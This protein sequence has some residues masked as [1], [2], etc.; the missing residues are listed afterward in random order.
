M[1]QVEDS[2]ETQFS[3]TETDKTCLLWNLK[4]KVGAREEHGWGWGSTLVGEC[5]LGVFQT[6]DS[7]LNPCTKLVP[8]NVSNVRAHAC[9]SST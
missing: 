1:P 5:F 2:F 7:R 8:G 4:E 6:F 3:K 9:N